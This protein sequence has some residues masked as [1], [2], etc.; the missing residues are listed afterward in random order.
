M[1]SDKLQGVQSIISYLKAVCA[2]DGHS[3]VLQFCVGTG[4]KQEIA[5]VEFTGKGWG[6]G[7]VCVS[8]RVG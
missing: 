2:G 5:C 3:P 4:A 7:G 6:C 1:N 8:R